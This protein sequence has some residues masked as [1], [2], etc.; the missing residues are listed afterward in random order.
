MKKLDSQKPLP[1]T[2]EDQKFLAALPEDWEAACVQ[3][4]NLV[5]QRLVEG[6]LIKAEMVAAVKEALRL[7]R[8]QY[9]RGAT[10]VISNATREAVSLCGFASPEVILQKLAERKRKT[11]QTSHNN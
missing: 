1:E 8:D 9:D 10:I 2:T 11:N 5:G 7:P 4:Q 3:I 6:N